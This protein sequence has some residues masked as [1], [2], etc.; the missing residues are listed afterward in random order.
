[1]RSAS[2]ETVQTVSNS[3]ARADAVNQ[4]ARGPGRE[5]DLELVVVRR[6]PRRDAG[7]RDRRGGVGAR[8]ATVVARAQAARGPSP[9]S[10]SVAREP[11]A[12]RRVEPA[13]HGEV[14]AGAVREP[15]EVQLRARAATRWASYGS[16]SRPSRRI[17]P[18][19]PVTANQ[20]SR[21]ATARKPPIVTS[22]TAA[23]SG[24]P[25]QPVRG[26]Q[27]GA[28]ER[29]GRRDA[30]RMPRPAGRGPAASRAA[31]ARRRGVRVRCGLARSPPVAGPPPAHVRG[32][33]SR[34]RDRAG[35]P[36]RRR[37]PA[38]NRTCA[39]GASSA[40]DAASGSNSGAAVV[41]ISRQPPG[42]SRG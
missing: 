11:S 10:R 37:A 18:H 38:R 27:R 4:S 25:T 39:P 3:V 34:A 28:V 40:G 29:P 7:D 21:P 8:P 31:R 42:V 1:M 17:R 26:A 20:R 33:M 32:A 16:T 23:P 6:A 15:V 24:L 35:A 2:F 30:E 36:T 14:G 13:A 19:A 41:P 22:I 5:L 12:A 9:A